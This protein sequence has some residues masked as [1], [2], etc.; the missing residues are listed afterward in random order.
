MRRK[1]H[2]RNPQPHLRAWAVC[3]PMA[4]SAGRWIATGHIIAIILQRPQTGD[5]PALSRA[6]SKA[7]HRAPASKPAWSFWIL[8]C[9]WG[10][11]NTSHFSLCFLMSLCHLFFLLHSFSMTPMWGAAVDGELLKAPGRCNSYLPE[12]RVKSQQ[13]NISEAKGNS[14]SS[15]APCAQQ[16]CIPGS[17]RHVYYPL[18]AQSGRF[19]CATAKNGVRLKRMGAVIY[20]CMP[21]CWD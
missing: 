20:G 7:Y 18:Y 21:S 6:L 17:T 13:R 19:V 16:W 10:L 3:V 5:C 8:H 14:I 11:K 4:G 1:E 2:F 9:R 15:L 12:K